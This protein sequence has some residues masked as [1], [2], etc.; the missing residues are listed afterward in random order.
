KNSP[1]PGL[2]KFQVCAKANGRTVCK[3]TQLAVFSGF[4]GNW[5][6]DYSGDPGAFACNTPLSGQIK[7]KLAQKVAIV[8]G[9]PQ[10]TF[11]G[12]ATLSNL[13]PIMTNT[14]DHRCDFSIQTFKL[15][16]KVNNPSAGADD[17]GNGLF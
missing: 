11:T 2:Y 12:T 5:A 4:N 15:T 3:A 17:S 6:G 8:K 16:G 14:D 9:V 10:S 7:L 13:P 1:T